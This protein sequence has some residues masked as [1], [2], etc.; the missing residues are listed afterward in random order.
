MTRHRRKRRREQLWVRIFLRLVPASH[1]FHVRKGYLY[2][3]FDARGRLL[4]VGISLDPDRRV[5]QHRR[6]KSWGSAIHLVK[7]KEYPTIGHAMEAEKQAIEN[8]APIHN[9]MYN[10][11]APMPKSRMSRRWKL[12]FNLSL[13]AFLI[14]ILYIIA[15]AF[16]HT[17]L[18]Q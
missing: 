4:Y 2:R 15:T 13:V 6:T 5:Q 14:W 8:E 1:K 9:V 12:F 18:V 7:T 16:A 17:T 3:L 11:V 10:T